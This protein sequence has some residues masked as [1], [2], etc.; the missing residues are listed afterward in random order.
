[1]LD[2]NELVLL[3][4]SFDKSHVKGDFEFLR[5]HGFFPGL[6]LGKSA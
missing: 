2:R 6:N 1:M 5:N 3:L 4:P